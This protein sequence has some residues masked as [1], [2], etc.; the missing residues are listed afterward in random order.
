MKK[1]LLKVLLPCYGA[2][3]DS[4]RVEVGAGGEGCDD[5]FFTDL[6]SRS[7]D[8]RAK[9]GAQRRDFPRPGTQVLVDE[10]AWTRRQH[11]KCKNH[12]HREKG[13][14]KRKKK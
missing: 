5:S 8:S 3:G 13:K 11:L 12:Q 4:E 10:R 14:R 7:C 6:I 9:R 1:M 2:P